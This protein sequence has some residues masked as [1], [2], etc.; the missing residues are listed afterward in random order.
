MENFLR[1]QMDVHSLQ[2]DRILPRNFSFAYRDEKAKV[3]AH[4]LEKWNREVHSQSQGAAIYEIFL[5][6]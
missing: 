3:S 6:E 5:V 2:A 1:I 4:I